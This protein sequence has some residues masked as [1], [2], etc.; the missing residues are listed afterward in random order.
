MNFG[1]FIISTIIVVIT[2]T[3]NSCKE[4]LREQ[5]L[6]MN[7][8]ALMTENVIDRATRAAIKFASEAIP[9]S[10]KARKAGERIRLRLGS[11]KFPALK[12]TFMT[13]V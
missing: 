10:Y 3:A 12:L 8:K 1:A 2:I 11:Q 4:G 9:G 7:H 13:L 6:V 5:E